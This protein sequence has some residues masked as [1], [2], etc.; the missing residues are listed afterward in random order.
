[1]RSLSAIAQVFRH[2]LEIRQFRT[3]NMNGGFTQ[4]NC[5]EPLS[6]LPDARVYFLNTMSKYC[7]VFGNY[8]A[9]CCLRAILY[10]STSPCPSFESRTRLRIEV[11]GE[12]QISVIV[13]SP[14]C[15]PAM[16]STT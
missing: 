16:D 14:T 6:I 8:R 10:P 5:Y 3:T 2:I 15:E 9:K 7:A 4:E 13:S 12:I 11:L 1:M